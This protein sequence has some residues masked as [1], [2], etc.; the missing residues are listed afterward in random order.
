VSHEGETRP[1]LVAPE[2]WLIGLVAAFVVVVALVAGG[3][4]AWRHL[5]I[6]SDAPFFLGVGRHPF[7]SGQLPG[8]PLEYG[9]AYRYGRILFPLTGWLLALGRPSWVSAT[10][11]GTFI[12][13][14]GAWVAFAAEHLRRNG[15]RPALAL[16][17]LALPFMLLTFMRPVVISEP[18]A[19]A[20]LLLVYLFERD[21][22]R[23]GV[24]VTAALL[25]LTR[26]LMVVALL[27][28]MWAGWKQRRFAAV[29]EWAFV[30][31]PYA[32]WSVWVRLRVGQFPLLDPS[33]NRRQALA[34]P[35]TGYW[36]IW[37]LPASGT[38]EFA[39]ATAFLTMFVTVAVIVGARG[40]WRFPLTHGAL[41]LGA[42]V[43]FFGVSVFLFP[44]EALRVL[45]PIQAL[46]LI[47]ALDRGGGPSA[48]PPASIRKQS[49]GVLTGR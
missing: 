3:P 23:R 10:L 4:P 22:R 47:A 12:A 34:A 35:F 43:P 17:I 13:S 39:L 32:A 15:R 44:G 19:G 20:L 30:C 28:L 46:L 18:T 38:Q 45:V 37:R 7:G 6:D 2:C 36:H 48:S 26:E 25:V 42:V 33:T 8:N 27:P 14:I 31:L 16:W 24:Y 5:F 11:L 21:G 29:R 9:V 40:H 1:P 41:A 49:S